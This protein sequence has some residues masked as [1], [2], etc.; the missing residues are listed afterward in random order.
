IWP[1]PPFTDPTL[2][3]IINFSDYW[4]TQANL[5]FGLGE[6]RK[7]VTL[8]VTNDNAVEF[9]EEFLIS[10]SGGSAALGPNSVGTVTIMYDDA[11]AGALDR[12]WDPDDASTTFPAFNTTPGADATVN[13]IAVQPDGK[14]VLGGDFRNV[15]SRFLNHIA[16]M[17]TDGSVDPSFQPGNGADGVVSSVLIYPTNGPNANKILIAGGFNSYNGTQRNS[18]AR[19]RTDGSLDTTFNPGN[20]ANGPVRA[21][22]LQSDG[23]IVIAGDFTSFNDVLRLGLARLNS[24]GSLDLS[25]DPGDGPDGIVWTLAL[26]PDGQ[27]G[28]KLLAGGDFLTLNGQFRGGI[29]R[30]NA[31]GSVDPAFDPGSGVN[32]TIYAVAVLTNRQ[33]LLAG[34]FSRFNANPRSRMAQLQPDG[35]LDFSFDPGLGPND[36][37]F[38]LLI[39][40]DGK[41]LIGGPFTSYNGTRRVGLARLRWDGSLDTSFMDTAYNQFAGLPNEFSFQPPNFINSMALQ[42]DGNLIIGGSFTTVGGSPSA[43]ARLRNSWTVFTRADK[44]TRYNIARILGGATPGPGNVSFDT[45]DYYADENSGNA[46]IKV[47]RTD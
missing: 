26:Q 4:P 15:N 43:N 37:V 40:P 22:V 24:D 16:R 17:N 3:P 35:G 5:T 33:V 27:G 41:P 47:E 25:F 32:G 13:A 6:C 42:A 18:I 38:S 46:F 20:G 14:T 34:D 19:L 36:A 2:S 1:N 44:R 45:S 29:V 7:S 31:N 30:L 8:Y 39:Q 21:M 28:S 9:D 11:P 10:L 12:E 23:A